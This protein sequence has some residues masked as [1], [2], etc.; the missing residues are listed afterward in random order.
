MA[1][2]KEHTPPNNDL[3]LIPASVN[4]FTKA[5]DIDALMEYV[6]P[7]VK[8]ALCPF[9]EP[10]D[11]AL[12]FLWAQNKGISV[13]EAFNHLV[14]VN[15]RVG[16]DSFLTRAMLQKGGIFA[17]VVIT[18]GEPEDFRPLY[19]YTYRGDTYDQDMYDANRDQYAV[20]LSADTL[21]AAHAN[22]TIPAGKIPVVRSAQPYDYRTR[23]MFRRFIGKTVL[24]EVG[25]FTWSRAQAAGL[26]EKSNWKNYPRECQYARAYMTGARRIGADKMAETYSKEELY[27][28]HGIE[29]GADEFEIM[30]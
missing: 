27:T 22:G 21:K 16:A 24:Q 12:A 8:G 4:T 1:D 19:H 13:I 20:F 17:S 6:T 30:D 10:A 3:A 18:H 29:L 2:Q 11:A 23:L 7:F 26:T 15:G 28:E 5:G 9:Q 14:I 25:E